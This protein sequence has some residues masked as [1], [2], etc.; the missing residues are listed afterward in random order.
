[1]PETN[2][3]KTKEKNTPTITTPIPILL[4]EAAQSDI[5]IGMLQKYKLVIRIGAIGLRSF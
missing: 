5:A 1:L 4:V 3:V 2:N